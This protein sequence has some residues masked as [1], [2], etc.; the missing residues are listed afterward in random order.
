MGA[1]FTGVIRKLHGLFVRESRADA[2]AR[3]LAELIPHDASSILDVG[4]GD[5]LID[6]AIMA[7]RSGLSI[8]GIDLF[9]RPEALIPV[10]P[11]DGRAIPCADKSYDAVIFIDVLHHV[12]DRRALLQEAA[13]VARQAILIKDQ[14]AEGQPTRVLLRFMDLI[15]NAGYSFAWSA[16]YW[17][18]QQWQQTFKDLNLAVIESR[19]RLGLYPAPASWLFER[20]FHFAARLDL[21]ASA[22]PDRVCQGPECSAGKLTG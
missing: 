8:E 18:R 1:G 3:N 7:R 6:Q 17:S 11:F 9:P 12:S 5:G 21:N 13:R 14:F 4:C 2:I 19:N 16:N 15:G 10:R 20:T 22:I